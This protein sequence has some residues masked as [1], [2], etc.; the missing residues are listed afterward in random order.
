[1]DLH[2]FNKLFYYFKKSFP[3]P[4]DKLLFGGGYREGAYAGAMHVIDFSNNQGNCSDA[5]YLPGTGNYGMVSLKNRAGNPLSC[6]GY[7]FSPFCSEY[8]PETN[9]WETGPQLLGKRHKSAYTHIGDDGSYW[10]AGSWYT[11]SKLTS[12]IYNATTGTFLPGPYLPEDSVMDYGGPCAVR[13]TSSLTMFVGIKAYLY[14]WTEGTFT[15]T[16]SMPY[17]DLQIMH[18][19]AAVTSDGRQ[20]VVVAGG[21][22]NGYNPIDYVQI[23]D[24]AEETWRLSANRML[25]PLYGGTAVQYGDSFLVVGGTSRQVQYQNTTVEFH[26]D[27][28]TWSVKTELLRF[29]WSGMYAEMVDET[30]VFCLYEK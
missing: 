21:A 4:L 27:D 25:L 24:V 18:C 3:V 8:N 14:D 9:E 16:V 29:G 30:K 28:E 26:P 5:N 17:E 19:G 10:V 2:N 7:Y 6:G 20:M 11:E 23:Y 12:E 22:A 15:R 13:I 1:M